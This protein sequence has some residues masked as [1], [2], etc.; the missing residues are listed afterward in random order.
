MVA[1]SEGEVEMSRS[2]T[3]QRYGAEKA[4]SGAEPTNENRGKT[5][6]EEIRWKQNDV[7]D[8]VCS[9]QTVCSFSLWAGV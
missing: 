5:S 3:W 2:Q 7:G 8:K 4:V 6:Y 9:I 1:G